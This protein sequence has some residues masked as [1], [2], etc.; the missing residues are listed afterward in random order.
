MQ[1]VKAKDFKFTYPGVEK[2]ALDR[3]SFDIQK[4]EI[5]GIIGPVG[6]GKT[7]LCMAIAGLAPRI[8]GG[9]TSGEMEVHRNGH[10]PSQ[11][12]QDE[13]ADHPIGMVFE[14]YAGQLTQLKVLDEVKNPLIN[15][16]FSD[17]E[18]E[19]RARDL[20]NQVGLNLDE[21]Q[22]KRVWELS[23]GQ[24]QR[25]AIAA[26]LALDPQ[27]LIFDKAIDRLDPRGQDKVRQIIEDLAGEKTLVV[28]EQDTHLLQEIADRIL[29]IVDGSVVAEG[30]PEDILRD[31]DLVSHADATPPVSLRLARALGLPS[32]PLTFEEF[33]QA[34][35]P[36]FGPEPR[37]QQLGNGASVTDP[38]LGQTLV[39]VE[40]LSFCYPDGTQALKDVNFALREGEVRAIVGNSSAGK[41]TLVLNIAGLL[42]PSNGKVSVCGIDTQCS[43]A[44]D[45]AM[46][47]GTVFQNPDEHITERSVRDEIRF[48][49]RER[50]YKRKGLFGKHQRYDDQ[51]IQQKISQACELVGISEKLL[52]Q[53]PVLLPAGLRRLVT[54]AE[55]LA[56][57]P[58]VISLDEP[59]VGLSATSRRK[60][61]E[62]IARL[63]DMGKAILITENDVDFVAEVADT[64]T[65]MDRGQI[66]LQGSVQEVF[67]E[68]NWPQL[69]DLYI[70]PPYAAQLAQRLET[71]A[72]TVDELIAKLSQYQE[73]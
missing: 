43:S 23:G 21:L 22:K 2:S 18:A 1:I 64:I 36:K 58:Q 45:L 67:A 55:A 42:K 28:V 3:V 7:T 30:K 62:T 41:T 20:L 33:E 11:T 34:F 12:N 68:Q 37:Q 72:T 40:Q 71:Q 47:V 46:K 54:I 73:A 65:V 19:N 38:Q 4:G 57:D 50:Q 32:S 29:V 27:I 31:D 8:T 52:D 70:H 17:Q 48:P 66:V 16:G 49:L 44:T 56:V 61:K 26:T 14:D 63:R 39:Q 10:Q 9:E 60:L 51:Y 25:L 15:R 6:A 59:S 53:D 35:D 13:E 69:S 5:L 24:Q